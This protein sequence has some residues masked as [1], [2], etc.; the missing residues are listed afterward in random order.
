MA[1][2]VVNCIVASTVTKGRGARLNGAG[3]GG[4]PLALLASDGTTATAHNNVGIFLADGVSGDVV[5]VA[6]VGEHIDYAIAGASITIGALATTGAAGKVA[7]GA[8][9]DRCFLR[10]VRGKSSAGATA[11]GAQCA[12]QVVGPI[13][14]A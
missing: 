5:P 1:G 11:D 9:G 13:D 6:T 3:T 7:A 2:N 12:V 4:L 14:L 10:V 8:S